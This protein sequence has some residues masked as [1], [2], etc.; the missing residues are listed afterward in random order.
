MKNCKSCGRSLS[1]D[2]LFCPS[3]GGNDFTAE[4]AGGA[5]QDVRFSF[6]PTEIKGKVKAWQIIL[7][8]LG[9][10]ALVA[11]GIFAVKSVFSSN[12]V[13][14]SEPLAHGS[15]PCCATSKFLL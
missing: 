3:C 11:A 13:F 4:Q 14:I 2:A 1:D 8:A 15:L 6:T 10:I 7:V 9:C 5:S 12:G